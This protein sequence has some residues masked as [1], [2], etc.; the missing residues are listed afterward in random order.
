MSNTPER[1]VDIAVVGAGKAGA[2][3]VLAI[4]EVLEEVLGKLLD[5]SS[6]AGRLFGWVNVPEDCL[7]STRH[8][9]LHAARPAGVVTSWSATTSDC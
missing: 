8:I 3:M 9:H 4:E 6:E 1:Q 5:S 2:G 7:V